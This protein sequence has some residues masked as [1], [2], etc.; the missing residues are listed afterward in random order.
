[1]TRQFTTPASPALSPE[2][3]T[4][5][6]ATQRIALRRSVA[7]R[8]ATG[9]FVLVA[10]I[11]VYTCLASRLGAGQAASLTFALAAL[12][13]LCA[14]RCDAAQPAA[15]RF[16]MGEISVWNR[17][18][19]L[20]ARGRVV[21]CAQWSGRLLVLSLESKRGQRRGTALKP[22]IRTR[23]ILLAADALPPTVFRELSVL[24]RRAAGA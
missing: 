1:M 6:R 4:L 17:A 14:A 16:A 3:A 13:A 7:L 22:H 11:A 20:L 12:L 21:G 5:G 8:A 24:S 23:F 9:A 18:G 2:P 15:L 10:S 19:A